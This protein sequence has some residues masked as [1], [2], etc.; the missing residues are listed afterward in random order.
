MDRDGELN[1]AE[2]EHFMLQLKKRKEILSL[3]KL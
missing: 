3:Y 2:F 1:E